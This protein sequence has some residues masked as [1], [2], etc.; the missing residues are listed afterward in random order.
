RNN[1]AII[2]LDPKLGSAITEGLAKR[3]AEGNAVGTINGR[4]VY[5]V[6][7]DALLSDGISSQ[8]LGKRVDRLIKAAGQQKAILVLD[9]QGLLGLAASPEA[10]SSLR[11]A[12]ASGAVRFMAIISPTEFETFS[13]GN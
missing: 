9:G 4:S 8:V 2:S 10:N 6:R 12:L 7:T 1:P 3:I 13:T 11:A 5:M